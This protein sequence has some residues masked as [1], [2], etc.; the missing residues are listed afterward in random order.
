MVEGDFGTTV[1]RY[2]YFGGPEILDVMMQLARR[3]RED[4]LFSHDLTTAEG[5]LLLR[6]ELA[7]TID[8]LSIDGEVGGRLLRVLPDLLAMLAACA[9]RP[10]MLQAFTAI[11]PAI[12][13][14]TLSAAAQEKLKRSRAQKTRRSQGRSARAA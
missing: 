6:A 9:P 3:R 11:A 12:P 8:S 13:Q 1:R 14:E 10:T 7:M 2:A 4:G 5:R